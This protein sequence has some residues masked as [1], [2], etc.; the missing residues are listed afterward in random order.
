MNYMKNSRLPIILLFG[1]FLIVSCNDDFMERYPE[2]DI[3]D[4]AVWKTPL[5]LQLYVNNFYNRK[6]L[7][8][9]NEGSGTIGIYSYDRDA[10][11]DTQ[12]HQ[13]YNQRMNGQGSIP[14]TDD[15]WGSTENEKGWSALRDINYFFHNYKKATGDQKEINRYVGEALFFRALFYFKKVTL[16]GDVP[17]YESLLLPGNEELYKARDPRN[18]VVDKILEDLDTAIEYLPSRGADAKW[19]GRVNKEAA[20]ILQ[21]RVALYEGTW[22]KYHAGTDFG[23]EG[24]DGSKYLTKAKEVTDALMTLGTCDLDNIG[25]ENGYHRVFNQTSY[26][27]SKEVV[28]W[29]QYS[30][31]LGIAHWWSNYTTYGGLSGL[32]KRMIDMYLCTDG[33]PIEGNQLYKGD[34]TLLDVVANRDPR[35]NQTIYVNDGKHEQHP[36]IPFTYPSFVEY[37]KA[38]VTGY[39]MYKGHLPSDI[40][41]GA[42]HEQGMIYFRYAEA[43]LI[44][45]EAKAELEIITQ[46]DIDNTINK[47]RRRLVGMSDM[48]LDEVNSWNYEKMFP[49]LSNIINEIRRERTIELAVE[50]FRVDDIFRWAAADVLI[51]NYIPQGAKLAQWKGNLDPDP[52]EDFEKAVKGLNEDADGYIA[53]YATQTGFPDTGY[54]FDLGR[55]YLKAIPS[56]EIVLNPALVQNPGWE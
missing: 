9:R 8:P 29:R 13:N 24:S 1:L 26:A 52:G 25:Q 7:L 21:G 36:G 56:T 2:K 27:N 32:T 3:S 20:M 34:E 23:V 28:F 10:G 51:K 50:G 45:A 39:Q 5:D 16:Y 30:K 11:S 48:K 40:L 12:I 53:P 47:L 37:D 15:D 43:L 22:E 17:W 33:K 55:D 31:S 46:A 44:N 41:A 4:A 18:F 49:E 14:S 35:L 6:D 19:D 54:N 38:C 42:A